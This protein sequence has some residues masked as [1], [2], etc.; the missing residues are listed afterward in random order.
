MDYDGTLTPIVERPELAK[1]PEETCKL[2]QHLTTRPHFTLGIISGRALADLKALVN[3]KG[4]LYAGNHGF[5]IEGPGLSFISPIADEI[6]P[7]I[8]ILRQVLNMGVS[9]IKGVLV[10]D[11]GVTLSV[12]Y[13]QVADEGG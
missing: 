3:L 11:K 13:R 10:E 4:I 1:L 6:K 9:T 12:H 8:R 2:L 7:L 5:E